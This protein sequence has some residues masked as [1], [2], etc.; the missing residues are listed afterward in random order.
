MRKGKITKQRFHAEGPGTHRFYEEELEQER[1]KEKERERETERERRE[2]DF[3]RQIWVGT[4]L[5]P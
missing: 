2:R 5:G 1:K 3:Y 4:K